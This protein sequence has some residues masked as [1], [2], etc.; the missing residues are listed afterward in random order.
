MS[1][2]PTPNKQALK[3]LNTQLKKLETE[4]IAAKKV[5]SMDDYLDIKVTTNQS[6][7]K[8]VQVVG[9]KDKG[10]GEFFIE[11]EITAKKSDVY[12]PLSVASGK[13]PTGFVYQI[14]GTGEGLISTA[15]AKWRGAGVTEVTMGTLHYVKIPVSKT[16]IIVV[17][18]TIKGSIGKSYNLT[19]T[20]IN[21]KLS[22]SDARYKQHSKTISGHNVLLS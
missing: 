12:I 17:Q 21:F 3:E 10:V 2:T 1:N 8:R 15:A 6:H 14:E 5:A 20:V 11:L 4:L 19:I 18:I 22:P 9:N 16:A 13:K 7:S